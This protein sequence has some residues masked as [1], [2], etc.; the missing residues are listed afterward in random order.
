MFDFAERNTIQLTNNLKRKRSN[1]ISIADKTAHYR[2]MLIRDQ[3]TPTF[4]QII[5]EETESAVG[6]IEEFDFP[7]FR[8]A[9]L[10]S[11]EMLQEGE[12]FKLN[13][14]GANVTADMR[15][16][17]EREFGTLEDYSNG[18]SLARRSFQKEGK[19]KKY[20]PEKASAYWRNVIYNNRF[21]SDL[22]SSTIALRLSESGRKAPFWDLLNNGVPQPL[23]SGR[24]GTAYPTSGA[25]RF[26]DLSERRIESLANAEYALTAEEVS[27][28]Q[29]EIIQA[30][31]T[32]DDIDKIAIMV[33]RN[34]EQYTEPQIIQE[35]IINETRYFA[36]ITGTGKLGFAQHPRFQGRRIP[37]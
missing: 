6:E 36:Y 33:G 30:E 37:H 31:R 16:S 35:I 8:N 19:K 5:R 13:L 23:K 34:I 4:N 9:L 17:F 21:G 3:M 1:L 20:N 26:L 2:F 11:M 29:D 28:I 14:V 7:E 32:L 22:Y 18:I 25:T 24:G 12:L 15:E 27:Q 10:G